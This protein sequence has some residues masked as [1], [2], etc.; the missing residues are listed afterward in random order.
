MS[1]SRSSRP[2]RRSA[3]IA[4][5]WLSTA[6][7]AVLLVAGAPAQA[8]RHDHVPPKFAG[9]K[10]ATTCIPG[11]IGPERTSSYHLAWKAATDNVTP[12]SQIVYNVYEATKGWWRGLLKADVHDRSRYDVLRHSAATF[13]QNLLFRRARTRSGGQRRLEHH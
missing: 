7:V 6:A 1:A 11:P 8:L 10:S 3:A 9:L 4:S 12:P 5:L 2:R 13:R